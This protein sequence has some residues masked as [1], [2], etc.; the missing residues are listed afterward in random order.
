[1]PLGDALRLP[2]QI[3]LEPIGPLEAVPELIAVAIVA[4]WKINYSAHGYL[5]LKPLPGGKK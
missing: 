3:L 4:M 2:L 5:L 1:L